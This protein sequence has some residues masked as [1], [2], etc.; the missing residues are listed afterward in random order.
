MLR[1]AAQGL[2]KHL[3]TEIDAQ[4]EYDKLVSEKTKKGY[5]EV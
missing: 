4:R 3:D 5:L 2:E 1:Y